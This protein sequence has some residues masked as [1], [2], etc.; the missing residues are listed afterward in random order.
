M[1]QKNFSGILKEIIEQPPD[2]DIAELL[3]NNL[4]I[5]VDKAVVLADRIKKAHNLALKK[6]DVRMMVEKVPKTAQKS[7]AYLVECLSDK[8]FG[9]FMQWLFEAL[10]YDVQSRYLTNGGTNLTAIRNGETVAVLARKYPQDYT[11]TV[12]AVLDAQQTQRTHGYNRIILLATTCFTEQAIMEAQRYGVELWNSDVLVAKIEEAKEKSTQG[13]QQTSFPPYQGSLLLSLLS[14]A[15]AKIFLIE[16]KAEEKHDLLLPGVKYPL[17][18][19]EASNGTVVRCVFRIEYN[20]PVSEGD[21]KQLI[22]TDENNNRK[23]PPDLEAYELIIQYL[24]QFLE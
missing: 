12:A 22:E 19:F 9:G 15:E 23:G 14:L 18:T 20:E 10:G 11:L 13:N 8:E 24:S 3:S 2:S 16:S 4:Q 21:G 5:P 17:L 1:N 7:R 6:P